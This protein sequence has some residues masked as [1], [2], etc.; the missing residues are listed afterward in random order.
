VADFPAATPRRLFYEGMPVKW[1]QLMIWMQIRLSPT[2]ELL[3][4]GDAIVLPNQGDWIN[5][6]ARDYFVTHQRKH[7]FYETDRRVVELYVT[8]L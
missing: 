8:K 2:N 3:W 1:Q 5:I 7:V 4:E 6:K